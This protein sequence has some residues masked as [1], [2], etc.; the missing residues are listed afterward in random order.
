[1][2]IEAIVQ[3]IAKE[4]R[5]CPFLKGVVLGG[6]RATGCATESSDIDIG[7]Y[8]EGAIDYGQLNA[9][10]QRLD[11]AH[12]ENLV[13][14]EGEWGNWVN[15]G[16][17]LVINGVHVDWIL[18]D[19]ARVKRILA[20][21]E[22]GQFSAHYQTGHPHAF[23]DVMY[24]GE[25]ACCKILY[26]AD[27]EFAATKRQAERYPA[28]LKRALADFFSFESE[29]SCALAEKSASSEDISYVTGH[30]F[31]AVSALNQVL[32]A[33]NEQWCLNEKKAVF[34]ID[35]LPIA[36][37]NY[38]QT[39]TAIFRQIALSPEQGTQRLRALCEEVAALRA[40]H[41]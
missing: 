30:A 39:I 37:E 40:G 7:L 11:D 14:R 25:L 3:T 15:C 8:Y 2:P 29:F 34:R 22:A 35:G 24:R 31:R 38:S 27:E 21:S 23:L 6:S 17:W 18:R 36:P 20:S 9:I 13:C 41:K 12:R 16:G 28:A 4:L 26:A 1:M 32:F 19:C 5:A 33:L 10:A